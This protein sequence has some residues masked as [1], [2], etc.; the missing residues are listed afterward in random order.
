LSIYGSDDDEQASSGDDDEGDDSIADMLRAEQARIDRRSPLEKEIAE[1]RRLRT[2]FGKRY[3]RDKTFSVIRFYDEHAVDLHVHRLL[4]TRVQSAKGDEASCE[5]D[6]SSAGKTWRSDNERASD[7]L[8]VALTS[9]PLLAKSTPVTVA[10]V[11]SAWSLLQKKEKS[12]KAAAAE[13]DGESDGSDSSSDGSDSESDGSDEGSGGGSD[14]DSGSRSGRHMQNK[15]EGNKRLG[16][17][18]PLDEEEDE[19][20]E[21]DEVLLLDGRNSDGNGG[22]DN[23]DWLSNLPKSPS[24]A[25]SLDRNRL[26]VQIAPGQSRRVEVLKGIFWI[27][28]HVEGGVQNGDIVR[29][30][31]GI[32]SNTHLIIGLKYWSS[33]VSGHRVDGNDALAR[34]LARSRAMVAA[35]AAA[36]LFKSEG[37]SGGGSSGDGSSGGSSSGGSS[38]AIGDDIDNYDIN[39]HYNSD[40][41]DDLAGDEEDEEEEEELVRKKKPRPSAKKPKPPAKNKGSGN[42]NGSNASDVDSN[43][44]DTTEID[45]TENH[46]G[47]DHGGGGIGGSDHDSGSDHGGGG[48]GGSDHDSGSDHGGGGIGGSDHDSGDGYRSGC[49]H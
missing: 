7:E 39:E 42:S 32:P 12:K 34:A 25:F 36:V 23:E 4:D 16:R 8:G 27:N 40:V 44:T 11:K 37:S 33:E 38:G 18:G 28:V 24:G 2:L 26:G 29:V 43:T 48:I 49:R 45:P 9:I 35:A 5:R 14:S 47:G 21:E 13:A 41:N 17:K 15:S 30:N 22:S 10:Q 19:E 1:L 31:D 6:F 46:G 20:D 3:R